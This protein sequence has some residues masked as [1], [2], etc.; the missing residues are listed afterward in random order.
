ML[1]VFGVFLPKDMLLDVFF[2]NPRTNWVTTLSK[3]IHVAKN[4]NA[5]N[6]SPFCDAPTYLGPFA[7]PS[8]YCDAPTPTSPYVFGVCFPLSE[9]T[10]FCAFPTTR[11]GIL[12]IDLSWVT[13]SSTICLGKN[14]I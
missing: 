2:C 11:H 3:A 4:P 12:A 6:P 10:V 8:P 13:I 5:N 9:D 7:T 14:T 1:H